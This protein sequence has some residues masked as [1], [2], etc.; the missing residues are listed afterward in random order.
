MQAW[1]E[2]MAAY[3]KALDPNHLVTVGAE[4]FWGPVR[5]FSRC[6]CF[7]FF[8]FNLEQQQKVLCNWHGHWVRL[9]QKAKHAPADVGCS[10]PGL[11]VLSMRL[12]HVCGACQMGALVCH[13]SVWSQSQHQWCNGG[14]DQQLPGHRGEPGGGEWQM[15]TRL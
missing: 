2:E 11:M 4:G 8:Y 5:H 1:I 10:A 9:F 15:G 6:C 7:P 14:C 12:T 3:V 13:V